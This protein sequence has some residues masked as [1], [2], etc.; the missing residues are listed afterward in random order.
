MEEVE[1]LGMMVAAQIVKEAPEDAAV[2]RLVVILV[3]QGVLVIKVNQVEIN[4]LQDK[5]VV[6]LVDLVEEER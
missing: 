2:D 5:M 4:L 6:S 1:D 3:E